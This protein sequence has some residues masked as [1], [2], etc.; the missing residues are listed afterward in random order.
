M[1]NLSKLIKGIMFLTVLLSIGCEENKKTIFLESEFNRD[2]VIIFSDSSSIKKN[3][4]TLFSVLNHSNIFI[5]NGTKLDYGNTYF[6][7]DKSEKKEKYFFP[8]LCTDSLKYI[9]AHVENGNIEKTN[10]PS[11]SFN[12]LFFRKCNEQIK[13]DSAHN[14]LDS[15]LD[16]L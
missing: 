14:I 3:Q 4:D 7:F 9:L 10:K 12:I 6:C 8:S 2:I 1:I 16:S 13:V 15:Y 5:Y 11:V